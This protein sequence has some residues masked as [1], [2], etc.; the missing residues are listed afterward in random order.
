MSWISDVRDELQQLKKSGPELRKFGL[1]VGA[2]FL[3][4]GVAGFFKHWSA[5]IFVTAGAIGIL[6]LLCGWLRPAV[7]KRAYVVWM[8]IAFVLGWVVS[9][10]IL[11]VLFYVVLTPLG[12]VARLSG[13]KFI[14]TEFRT[15]R[16]SL[17]IAK[18]SAKKTNYEKMV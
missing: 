18:E 1:L 12:I 8:G 7:L 6:L 14:A 13:K 9:R 4:F 11:I 16:V 17:W 3:L 5:E 15:Q 10:L 2:V